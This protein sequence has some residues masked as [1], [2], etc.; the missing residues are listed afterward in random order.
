MDVN[1]ELSLKDSMYGSVRATA[2]SEWTSSATESAHNQ[3]N[4]NHQHNATN[5]F[6]MAP[7]LHQHNQQQQQQQQQIY[8]QKFRADLLS[9]ASRHSPTS[10]AFHSPVQY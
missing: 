2:T 7:Y 9:P 8:G 3:L 10:G 1:I 6:N 5:V 4:Y